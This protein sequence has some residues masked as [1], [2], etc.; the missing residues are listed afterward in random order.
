[1]RPFKLSQLSPGGRIE[2]HRHEAPYATLLL[3]GSYEEAGDAG[4]VVAVAGE[5]LLHAPFACH[6]NRISAQ[7]T[8]VVDL[9]LPF[10][11][12]RYPAHA[13]IADPDAVARLTERDPAAAVASLLE[14]LVPL[15]VDPTRTPVDRLASELC[16]TAP[17]AI[18]EWALGQGLSREHLSRQFRAVYGV[19]A[20]SYRAE[21]QAREAWFAIVNSDVSLA[22][23]AADSG[24]ADQ[25]HMSRAVARLTGRSPGQWR[26]WKAAKGSALN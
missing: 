26:R 14:Q 23:V 25:A 21:N 11:G 5:V 10:D 16:G 12:R 2:R 4:R 1:M 20:A 17:L 19:A 7:H 24:F 15:G 18:C 13:T 22:M 8:R 6:Q 9:P 3:T